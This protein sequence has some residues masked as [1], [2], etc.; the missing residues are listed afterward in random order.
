[1]PEIPQILKQKKVLVAG[2]VGVAAVLAYRFLKPG[3]A[4]TPAAQSP[5]VTET[6]SD[7]TPLQV[8]KNVTAS[9]Q[10]VTKEPVTVSDWVQRVWGVYAP[11]GQYDVSVIN[12]TLSKILNAQGGESIALT[13]A[14][15]TFY[16]DAL[17]YVDSA[18]ITTLPNVTVNSRFPVSPVGVVATTPVKLRI[19]K[20]L[21][22]SAGYMTWDHAA[23]YLGRVKGVKKIT[24]DQLRLYHVSHGGNPIFGAARG[25][26]IGS[27]LVYPSFN[28]Y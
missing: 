26:K 5:S 1:M 27:D 13:D 18:Q 22:D 4:A 16:R 8:E 28:P 17:K 6:V 20:G 14:E 7:Y 2:G 12:N 19:N 3:G 9:E 10:I 24:G 23:E 25:V 15:S 11:K 21:V